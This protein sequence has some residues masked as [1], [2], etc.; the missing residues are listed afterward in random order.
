MAVAR[1]SADMIA[2][3][4]TASSIAG[5]PRVEQADDS[6]V[7]RQISTTVAPFPIGKVLLMRV[8]GFWVMY[9]WGQ[10]AANRMVGGF[11]IRVFQSAGDY[12]RHALN[13][14]TNRSDDMK[15]DRIVI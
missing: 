3:R 14:V 7:V 15:Q 13:D 6:S 1:G 2:L 10:N 8:R 4:T 9:R 11:Y 12:Y 5:C